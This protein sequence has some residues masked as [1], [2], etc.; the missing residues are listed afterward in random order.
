MDMT[1]KKEIEIKVKPVKK[2]G[3]WWMI[4]NSN[5]K[6]DFALTLCLWAFIICVL[7]ALA[8]SFQVIDVNGHTITFRA[9]DVGF[10]TTVFVPTAMLYFGRRYQN[11]VQLQT[12]T[13]KKEEEESEENQGV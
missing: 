3:G 10:A 11:N 13:A 6:K 4:R 7:M 9:F 1:N 8:S 2:E 5:G 12:Q